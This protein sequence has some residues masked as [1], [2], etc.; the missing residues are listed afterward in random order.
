REL[1]D[2]LLAAAARQN[3][4]GDARFDWLVDQAQNLPTHKGR[5]EFA[6]LF[7][8]FRIGKTHYGNIA[9]RRC[10]DCHIDNQVGK[11]LASTTHG[12]TSMIARAEHIQLAAHRGGVE[13]RQAGVELDSAV[14]NHIEME[15]L[16]HDFGG[17]QV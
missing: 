8:K 1:R 4:K 14:D 12:L 13:T 6:R 9:V 11:A 17:K 16:V 2:T 15:A 10:N 3:L 7:E 5:P